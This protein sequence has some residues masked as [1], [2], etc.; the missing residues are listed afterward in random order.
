MFDLLLLAQV[1]AL[2]VDPG[3]PLFVLLHPRLLLLQALG[4]DHPR[5]RDLAALEHAVLLRK[6][7]RGRSR[8]DLRRLVPLHERLL[9]LQLVQVALQA[10]ERRL[11]RG[12]LAR[13]HHLALL[14]HRALALQLV[15]E[16]HPAAAHWCELLAHS[17]RDKFGEFSRPLRSL[18]GVG[19]GPRV[20]DYAADELSHV[21]SRLRV[22]VKGAQLAPAHL[23]ELLSA[24]QLHH[25]HPLLVEIIALV[26]QILLRTRVR[27]RHMRERHH[28]LLDDLFF[29]CAVRPRAPT[30][31]PRRPRLLVVFLT[32]PA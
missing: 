10:R 21:V 19:F 31:T 11:L 24:P 4:G 18:D 1:L 7:L 25:A 29:D 15:E 27:L 30:L 13:S 12:D 17:R 28:L 14:Q 5:V 9:L 16:R 3:A 6:A 2:L 32:S 8:D 22:H 20:C 23:V 26:G